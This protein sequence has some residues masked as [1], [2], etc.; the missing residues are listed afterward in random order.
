VARLGPAVIAPDPGDVIH[1]LAFTADGSRLHTISGERPWN[2]LSWDVATWRLHRRTGRFPHNRLN[3]RLPA[4]DHSV[5]AGWDSNGDFGLFALPGGQYLTLLEGQAEINPYLPC[6]FCPRG[7]F[8]I[9]TPKFGNCVVFAVPS[10]KRLYEVAILGGACGFSADGQRLAL[11][12]A[13]GVVEVRDAPTG[14]LLWRLAK[15]PAE[16]S[17][18]PPAFGANRVYRSDTYASLALSA[19]GTLLA[20]W[21]NHLLAVWDLTTPRDR[22]RWS[23]QTP[24]SPQKSSVCLAWSPDGRLLAVGAVDAGF[25]IRV[26]E[27]AT[28]QL[29]YQWVGHRQEVTSLAFSP[30]NRLLASGSRDGTVVVWDTLPATDA[31]PGAG[32]VTAL[33]LEELWADLGRGAPTAARAMAILAA[34]PALATAFLKTR[35]ASAALEPRRSIAEVVDD[36][37]HLK[38][39]IRELA[40]RE[41]VLR[42]ATVRFPLQEHL[43]GKPSLEVRRRID[44]ILDQ[45][46]GVVREPERL[47]ELRAVEVLERLG[48]SEARQLL[49]WL[50]EAAA[51]SPL[52]WEARAALGRLPRRW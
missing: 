32:G 31:A 12:G 36:L 2:T 11:R 8:L 38:Y 51:E 48:T 34:A 35:L 14:K 15:V 22:P 46:N 24:G 4:P 13:L 30:D 47:R 5:F 16:W 33:A 18:E 50:A 44:L 6:R 17:P 42:G 3:L 41:L 1:Q 26:W 52:T 39:A 9:A 10:G 43:R 19:D 7:Q 23:A 20:G 29:R 45:L 27:V 21:C 49:G 40:T 28:G 25:P 37:D